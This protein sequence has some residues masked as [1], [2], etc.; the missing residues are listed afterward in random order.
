VSYAVADSRDR[1][2][3]LA[4]LYR[5]RPPFSAEFVEQTTRMRLQKSLMLTMLPAATKHALKLLTP[6]EE[7]R[8]GAYPISGRNPLGFLSQ[9]FRNHLWAAFLAISTGYLCIIGPNLGT[10][11]S[12][13]VYINYCDVLG[14]S[15]T[16]SFCRPRFIR[17]NL[18]GTCSTACNGSMVSLKDKLAQ[19]Y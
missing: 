14:N 12:L 10:V 11:S 17:P 9:P 19:P 6:N 3:F 2:K 4:Q 5:L 1:S 15:T 7:G 8:D 13:V 18:A 16:R